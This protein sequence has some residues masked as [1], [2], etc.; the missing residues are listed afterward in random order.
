MGYGCSTVCN[1]GLS[2]L[3]AEILDDL[4]D[5]LRE[6]HYVGSNNLGPTFA[7]LLCSGLCFVSILR[8]IF[9][10]STCG[11]NPKPDVAP[12][13]SLDDLCLIA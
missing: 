5:P 1:Y 2:L 10:S 8:F 7:E 11:L 3:S 6:N 12:A 13:G 9:G 4:S